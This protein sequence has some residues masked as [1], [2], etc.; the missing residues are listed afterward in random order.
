MNRENQVEVQHIGVLNM[1][2]L[3]CI[4]A[5][6][7]KPFFIWRNSAPVLC[8]TMPK[9]TISVPMD[10]FTCLWYCGRIRTRL[11]YPGDSM[12]SFSLLLNPRI[13]LN[14]ISLLTLC[15]HHK[16]NEPYCSLENNTNQYTDK[17]EGVERERDRERGIERERETGKEG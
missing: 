5:F 7:R 4:L 15:H 9:E 3:G 6:S 16:V 8:E 17:G 10:V 2:V 1:S 13:P 14:I 12:V 11:H